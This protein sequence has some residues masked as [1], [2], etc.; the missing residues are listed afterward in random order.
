MIMEDGFSTKYVFSTPAVTLY[1]E[2]TVTPPGIDGGGPTDT[3]TMHNTAWRTQ[4]PKKLKSLAEAS[5]TVAYD[6]AVLPEIVA[7]VNVNQE[8]EI[9]FPDG[10]SWTFW[11]YLGSFEP[12]ENTEGEQPTAD[13]TI[14]PTNRNDLG[15]EVA[16]AYVAPIP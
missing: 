10:S 12:G 13:I 4:G 3:T 9:Q 8:M 1:E 6:P 2:K 11:G 5:A 15:V 16:P 14:I 7:A